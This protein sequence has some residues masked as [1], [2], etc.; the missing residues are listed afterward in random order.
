M[1]FLA[2]K[3][4]LVAALNSV[5][6][7]VGKKGSTIAILSNIKLEVAG[8][9]LTMTGTDLD[10]AVSVSMGVQSSEDGATTVSA[11]MFFD[12]AKKIPD[13]TQISVDLNSEK[14]SIQISYGKSKFKLPCLGA[15]GFPIIDQGVTDISFM[16]KSAN[17][18][19]LI[20]R[21]RFAISTDETRYYLTGVYMHIKD[22]DGKKTLRGVATDGHRLAVVETETAEPISEMP[23]IIIPR[24]TIGEIKRIMESSG[25]EEVKM[26][27]SRTKIKVEVG[28]TVL[29]SK[30]I[31]GEF[32]DYEKV[33]PS[34]NDTSIK[35]KAKMLAESIDRVSTVATDRHRS[36]KFGLANGQISLQVDTNDG[37]FASEE[38]EVQYAGDAINIGFNARY[39]LDILG[40][41]STENCVMDFK[42]GNSPVILHNDDESKDL[43]VLM[44]IRV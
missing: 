26:M 16:I 41:I 37:G 27:L 18:A 40:Q 17:L 25:V 35:V 4:A 29:I 22:I 34:G 31:D 2:E 14:T 24:K 36:I 42:D 6:G 32:P 15:E 39:V 7:A 20:D 3:N 30:L 43:F 13:G 33:I 38:L 8:G 19:R 12:I 9:K 28:G 11:Q 1:R 44:P 23:G 5:N 10:I 21:T